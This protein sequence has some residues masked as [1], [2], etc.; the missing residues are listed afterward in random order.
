MGDP[1]DPWGL[2]FHEGALYVASR[3]PNEVRAFDAMSGAPSA[4]VTSGSGGL[5]DPTSLAFGPDGN[6]Y[7]TSTGDDAIRRYAGSNGAFLGVFVASGSGGLDV[8]FDLAFGST[9]LG[10]PFVP[11]VPPALLAAALAAGGVWILRRKQRAV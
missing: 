4:F 2:V 7:V 8:P 5:I 1:V 9:A 3:F 6:L 11:G 10:A